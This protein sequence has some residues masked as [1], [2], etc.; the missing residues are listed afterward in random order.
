GTGIGLSLVKSLVEIHKGEIKVESQPGKGSVFTVVLPVHKSAFSKKELGD[1]PS[2]RE[3]MDD[4]LIPIK[5]LM[6]SFKNVP[7]N[8]NNVE[9]KQKILIIEDNAELRKY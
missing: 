7:T 9:D 6:A 4:T 5:K 1:F 2:N 8:R 3:I